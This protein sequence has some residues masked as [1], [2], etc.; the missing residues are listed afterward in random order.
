M[1]LDVSSGQMAP[2][3]ASFLSC[4]FTCGLTSPRT[5]HSH[6]SS[7]NVN[8]WASVRCKAI[9]QELDLLLGHFLEFLG[10]KTWGGVVVPNFCLAVTMQRLKFF[11][12]FWP[13]RHILSQVSSDPGL[14]EHPSLRWIISVV[15]GQ[16]SLLLSR[17]GGVLHTGYLP[18]LS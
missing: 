3:S 16:T 5:Q 10:I 1:A 13:Q 7:T 8:D 18:G 6:F 17:N 9:Y 4:I 2:V 11:Q 15:T 12:E 14:W